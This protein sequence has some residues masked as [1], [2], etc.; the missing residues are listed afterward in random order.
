MDEI[1]ARTN[2]RNSPRLLSFRELH[3]AFSLVELLIVVAIIILLASAVIPAT[4]NVL[5]G[6]N[7]NRAGQMV[8]DQLSVARQEAVSR[9]QDVEV[10]FY[11]IT[12]GLAGGWRALR[13]MRI[14]QTPTGPVTNA[15][16]RLVTL[17][18][19]TI[20]SVSG[21]L[22]PLISDA[23]SRSEALGAYGQVPYRALKFRPN[24]SLEVGVG[25]NNYLTLVDRI[26]T[27][28]SPANYYTIQIN[29]LSGKTTVFRP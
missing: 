29:S 19:S 23:T 3:G 24:G 7:L 9:N 18:D 25:T 16:G 8:S 4:S 21:N 2:R 27:S 22:S 1:A 20:I 13:T 28:E 11:N 17:P 6:A 14:E 12:N 26:E 15:L 10:R 5:K